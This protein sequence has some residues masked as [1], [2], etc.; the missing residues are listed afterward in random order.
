MVSMKSFTALVAVAA[1]ALVLSSCTS[2]A[3]EG[4]NDNEHGDLGSNTAAAQ[5]ADVNDADVAFATDMIPHHEQAVE[6]AAMVPGRSTDPEVVKLAADI[7]AAQGPEI[8]TMK[9]FLV[10][11]NAASKG[12]QEGHEGHETG[13]MEMTGMVDEATMTRLE[14]LKGNEFDT[15]WLSSMVG[16]HE[17]AIAMA[18]AEIADGANADAKKLAEQIATAQKAE[19]AQM[20]KMGMLTKNDG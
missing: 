17:G 13:G 9:A 20:R 16:H 4:H 18:G 5:P 10:Q 7:S 8:E 6:M 15:L 2:P 14:S 3:S 19:I 11:W 12:G 1:I